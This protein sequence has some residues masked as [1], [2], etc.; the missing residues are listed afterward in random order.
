MLQIA[1]NL[2]TMAQINNDLFFSYN[3]KSGGV[4]SHCCWFIIIVKIGA[5][6]IL[7]AFPSWLKDGCHSSGHHIYI[8]NGKKAV[9]VP[10]HI[11]GNS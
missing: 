11:E 7:L 8:Q 1:Q 2:R 5:Y 3:K 6:V 9:S 10:F 4:A